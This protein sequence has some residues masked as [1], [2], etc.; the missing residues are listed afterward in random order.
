MSDG[1]EWLRKCVALRSVHRN[2]EFTPGLNTLLLNYSS[3]VTVT[4]M[5]SRSRKKRD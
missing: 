3:L 1:D 2:D 4:E 5:F